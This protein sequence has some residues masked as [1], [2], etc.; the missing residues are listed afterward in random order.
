MIVWPCADN[1]AIIRINVW[2]FWEDK[3]WP[4]FFGLPHFYSS[5]LLFGMEIGWLMQP[6]GLQKELTCWRRQINN[7]NFLCPWWSGSHC[8]RSQMCLFIWK[9]KNFHCSEHPLFSFFCHLGP[10][11]NPTKYQKASLVTCCGRLKS[12]LL[13]TGKSGVKKRHNAL[14]HRT[15]I[16]VE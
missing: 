13:V 10:N 5:S 16:L 2:K 7:T 6:F 3:S 12:I 15:Y 11:S 1:W 8:T 14:F 9:T 4:F